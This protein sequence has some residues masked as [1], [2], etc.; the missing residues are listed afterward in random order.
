[1]KFALLMGCA[2]ACVPAL[3]AASEAGANE[4][5]LPPLASVVAVMAEYPNVVAAR[6]G[7][8][9]QDAAGSLLRAGTYETVVRMEA[10]ERRDPRI[11]TRFNE[12]NA[13]VER[14]LRL[15]G[16][17][18]LDARIGE[19]GMDLAR[20]AVGDALHEAGRTLLRQWFAWMRA[21]AV[22]A[23]WRAQLDVL[24][25]ERD[26]A[27]RRVKLGDAP[28]QEALLADA[29]VAQADYSR[30]QARARTEAA[31]TELHQTFPGIP[32]PAAPVLLAPRPIEGELDYWQLAY[33]ANNHELGLARAE[34][35]RR[36]LV[37]ARAR[38]DAIPDPTVGMRY[39]SERS[40]AEHIVGLFV[41]L[42]LPGEA[43]T[44]RAAESAAQ[45]EVA[46]SREAALLR[47]LSAEVSVLYT[48][49]RSAYDSAGRAGE[50]AQGMNRNA[51]L[52]SKAHSLGEASL[53]EVLLARR[54][55]SES[56]LASTLARLEAAESRYRLLLDAHELWPL[57]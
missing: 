25:A 37:A 19:E 22:E 31:A 17:A 18:R 43:R 39:A 5:D 51:E 41:S 42:P 9:A 49:A 40:N 28:R 12:W 52:T 48:N 45:I 54:M 23:V 57:D 27:A 2:L 30:L 33:L 6:A 29:A 1:M 20:L 36:T 4:P 32:I 8:R 50:A 7:E 15:P 55:A 47:R 13:V 35:R 14:P 56:G 34:I 53:A 24:V 10:G 38:A 46:A 16:K 21:T 26:I 11:D 3:A 44:A